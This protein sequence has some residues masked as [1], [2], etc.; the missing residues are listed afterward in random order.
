MS[1]IDNYV[2]DRR[3]E[4]QGKKYKIVPKIKSHMF[5]FKIWKETMAT[6]YLI[7]AVFIIIIALIMQTIT[8]DIQENS[9]RYFKKLLE[10]NSKQNALNNALT[11]AEREIAQQEFDQVENE[12]LDIY[13]YGYKLISRIWYSYIILIAYFIRNI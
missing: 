12:M 9:R 3:G 4:K 8:S 2:K 13:D 1:T 6:R 10:F 11:S 5:M 7:D